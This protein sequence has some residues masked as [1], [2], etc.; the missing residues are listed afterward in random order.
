M[1]EPHL[2][3]AE[4]DRALRKRPENLDAYDLYLQALALMRGVRAKDYDRALILLDQAIALDPGFAPALALCSGAHETRLTHGGVAPPGVDDRRLL[5]E[6]SE[7]A[8]ALDS[9]DAMVVMTAGTARL[10][11]NGDEAGGFSLLLR[12]EALN[13][14]SLIIAN[15]TAWCFWHAGRTDESIARFSRVIAM[16]RTT[17]EVVWS[18][19]GLSGAYLSAGRFEEALHW[20][21]Q[22]LERTDKLDFAHCQVVAAYAHLEQEANAEA[23]L[24]KT[25]ALWPD[26]TVERLIGP[27]ATPRERF[28]F[29]EEGLLKAGLPAV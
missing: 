2:R 23:R 19:S 24:K 14:N 29:L 21:L 17:P 20:G 3:R 7:R 10:L 6:L 12:A 26:L 18:M 5:L 13:P 15:V 22:V 8:L 25:L 28:R 11:H 9:D 4:I 27:K 1:F 16:A